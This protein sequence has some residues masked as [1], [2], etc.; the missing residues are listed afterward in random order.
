MKMNRQ[1]AAE[2]AERY[3]VQMK[4]CYRNSIVALMQFKDATYVEGLLYLPSVGIAIQHGW[5]ENGEEII[6]VTLG[7]PPDSR[8]HSGNQG[9]WDT[10]ADHYTAVCRY[11][12]EET[13]KLVAQHRSCPFHM[14]SRDGIMR[15]VEAERAFWQ[16]MNDGLKEGAS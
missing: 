1:I 7:L 2:L 10:Q 3:D 14:F 5:I 12:V 15:M 9:N 4:E 8:S 13:I 16:R 11:T 6:D